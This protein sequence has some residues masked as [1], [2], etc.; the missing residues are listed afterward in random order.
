M[1]TASKQYKI[2]IKKA[3]REHQNSIIKKIRCLKSS[4]SK[5]YWKLLFE[6][7]NKTPQNNVTL[8]DFKEHFSNL[9]TDET[10]EEV[11]F[12]LTSH[13]NDDTILNS[14]FSVD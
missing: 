2:K 4:D 9:N 8:N 5:Q 7:G 13:D 3:F 1:V 10:Y 14:Y 12:T 6:N 11:I